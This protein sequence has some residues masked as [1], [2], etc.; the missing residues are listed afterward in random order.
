[1][2]IGRTSMIRR[3]RKRRFI[4]GPVGP[5]L[6]LFAVWAF[7]RGAPPAYS[8]HPRVQAVREYQIKAAFLFNFIKFVE[9]PTDGFTHRSTP[10]TLGVLGKDPFG[11]ALDSLDGKTVKGRR[12]VVKRS[13]SLQDL[14]CSHILF[15]S[16]SENGHLPQI[17]EALNNSSV[18]T[19]G[20]AARFTRVGGIINFVIK[21]N[22]IRFEINVDAAERAGFTI[23]SKL[24]KLA[25]VIRNRPP[26]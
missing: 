10:I 16:S 17:V 11:T 2:R 24:L 14:Q 6:L 13:A 5:V 4:R 7:T 23:S 19:V 20:E 22:K 15:I 21:K 12:L 9:W 25:T 1:M 18:L 3:S 26:S 8:D